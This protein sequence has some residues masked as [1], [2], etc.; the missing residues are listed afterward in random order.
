MFM[1][2]QVSEMTMFHVETT[3]GTECIPIDVVGSDV[4]DAKLAG[5][6]EGEPYFDDDDNIDLERMTGWYA[7]F[8]AAGYTD[9]TD[10][11][12]PQATES[13]ALDDLAETHDVCRTCFEACWDSPEGDCSERG[14]A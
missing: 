12:G 6:L 10:W 2:P 13:G 1:Q 14:E 3:M 4:S 5:Y 8:S 7:R 9:A 11:V